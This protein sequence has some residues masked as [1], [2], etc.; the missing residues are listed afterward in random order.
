[1]QGRINTADDGPHGVATETATISIQWIRKKTW[2]GLV[3]NEKL[4]SRHNILPTNALRVNGEL[5]SLQLNWTSRNFFLK[6]RKCRVILRTQVSIGIIQ[7][8]F[9]STHFQIFYFTPLFKACIAILPLRETYTHIVTGVLNFFCPY[10]L[11]LPVST[12]FEITL[13]KVLLKKALNLIHKMCQ[14]LRINLKIY[15]YNFIIKNKI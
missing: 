9:L 8:D 4:T 11:I 1:M 6:W 5:P 7:S 3:T 15:Y 10:F 2:C 13:S 12:C 14:T